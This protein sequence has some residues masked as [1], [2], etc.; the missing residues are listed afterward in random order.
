MTRLAAVA[1][2]A[3]LAGCGA[4]SQL[5]APDE[6]GEGGAGGGAP[7]ERSCLPNCSIGH[8]CCQGGCGGPAVPLDSDCCVCLPGEVSSADCPGG[9]CAGG[10]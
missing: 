4:R 7:C 9:T 8:E 2:A 6:T 1:L 10:P 5:L 3:L